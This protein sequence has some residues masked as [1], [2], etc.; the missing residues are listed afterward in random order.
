MTA[1]LIGQIGRIPRRFTLAAALRDACMTIIK[2]RSQNTGKWTGRATRE[3]KKATDGRKMPMP[4]EGR[5]TQ[6]LAK[7]RVN[8]VS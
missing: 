8:P 2:H 4:R 5:E 3:G 7:S 1:T 6:R